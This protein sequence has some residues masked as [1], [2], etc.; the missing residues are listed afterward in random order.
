MSLV[1][2]LLAPAAIA[3]SDIAGASDPAGIVRVP[4]SWIVV[5]ERDDD[6]RNRE[7]VVSRVDKTRRDV[8]VE[9]E[10]RTLARLVSVT[11]EMPRNI[12]PE[13]V[14]NHYLNQFGAG[15][16]FSCRGRAC[17]RSNDW[18]NHIFGQA[19]LYGP[20]INQ[21]YFAGELDDRLLS[22]Y[23]IQRGNKRVYAH[24]QVLT[25]EDPVAVDFNREMV[26]QL[27]STGFVTLE[28]IR[29]EAGG[30]FSDEAIEQLKEL[31]VD[32]ARVGDQEVFVVCHLY[33]S[34]SADELLQSAALCSQTASEA[35][36]AAGGPNL[37]P[38][39]AGPLLPR[40]SG[41]VSRI[42]LVLP[43]RLEHN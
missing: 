36:G 21:Y 20:D 5:Y 8:R 7:F 15:E 30:S 3:A 35:L 9:R 27:S 22:L 40:R 31:A 33:G 17:G 38:F 18:A 12:R 19:I 13:E 1:L 26:D 11:Y 42:E 16:A 28:D 39:A 34:Q 23:V 24:L 10:V 32:L 37:K 41:N 4:H 2:L 43:H 14:I 25:P 6:L 29:P